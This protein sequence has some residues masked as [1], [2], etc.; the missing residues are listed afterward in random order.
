M[1]HCSISIAY[2]LSLR[3][4]TMA[5]TCSPLFDLTWKTG[6]NSFPST[7]KFPLLL[8]QKSPFAFIQCAPI[9]LKI[10]FHQFSLSLTF[11]TALPFNGFFSSA[12][13]VGSSFPTL[14]HYFSTLC[15]ALDVSPHLLIKS[16]LTAFHM[17]HPPF[18]NPSQP[19]CTATTFKDN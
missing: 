15:P 1:T 5:S 7:S 17:H 18:F 19:D 4:S 3:Y 12:Y 6:R 9:F 10:P 8:P 2:S 11:S 13:K 16:V 14:K